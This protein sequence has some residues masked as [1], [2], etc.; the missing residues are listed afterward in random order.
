MGEPFLSSSWYR[1]AGLRPKLRPHAQIHRHRYRGQAYY[2]LQDH[3]SGR[4]HRFTPAAYLFIGRMDGERT[5]D[6]IWSE[7]VEQ[8]EDDAPTQDEIVRLLS[9]LHAA[10]ILQSDVTPDA[11]ELFERYAKQQTTFRRNLRNPFAI[12]LPLWDPDAF[13]ERTLSVVGPL[14]GWAGAVL[15]LLV[16][17]PAVVLAS[18]HW[19]ELTHNLSD[20]VLATGNIALIALIY[21]VVKALHELGHAYAC[22]ARGGEVHQL[23]IML[24]VFFPAPYVDASAATAF[25]GKWQRAAVG[26]A[27]ILVEVFLAALALYAWIL[28]EPGTTRAVAFNV[29]LIAGVST[30][31]FNGNPLLRFDGYYVLADL[32]EIPNLAQRSAR[33]W[34][35][36]VDR[37]IFATP[38][39]EA[40]PAS[41][42]ERAWFMVY[43]PASLAYRL[44]VLFGIVL[45]VARE[46]FVIGVVI[47]AW[48]V[49]T[50]L[51]VPVGKMLAHVL[52]SPRLRRNRRRALAVTFGSLAGIVAALLLIPLPLHT[53]SEGVVWLPDNAHVRAGTDGFVQRLLVEP[54]RPVHVG[55][56]LIESDEPT[57][58]AQLQL[59]A[60]RIEALEARLTS[61]LVVD[62]IGAE[63]TRKELDKERSVFARARERADY[64]VARSA[65]D[66]RFIVPRPRDMTGRFHRQGEVLG[67]VVEPEARIV[68]VVVSQ[69]DS[70][71]VHRQMR[72]IEVKL[73]DRPAATYAAA[74]VREVPAATDQLP[75]KVLAGQGGGAIATDPRDHEGAKALSR[76]FQIDLALPPDLDPVAFGTRAY[77]RF[78]HTWEPLAWR[79]YRR[80]RQ[81]LLS[82]F[83]I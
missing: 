71:L 55:D 66:G 44:V 4:M 47:A 33:F 37:Y 59:L 32:I 6:A 81:L 1:V 78:D 83:D 21:P 18:V 39:V 22:K 43:A 20:R 2:V 41:G 57:L 15:W 12:T 50:S 79:L 46:F 72:A 65:A 5:V 45:F 51:L 56:P 67:Y 77:V 53:V 75:S 80:G 35:H 62:R 64:L 27:G 16:V 63:V 38:D 73:V 69:D 13:L 24:L 17:L 61:Q 11:G 28:F 40:Y 34:A 54:G 3:A 52:K 26:A 68:R 36:L 25:N 60:A 49:A 9:Q 48:G 19:P 23:G 10:D 82:H 8:L 70:E 7:V 74:I 58:A 31:V 14:F 30:V 42:G 29:M 76:Y